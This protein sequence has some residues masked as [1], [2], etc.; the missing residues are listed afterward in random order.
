[1]DN[2]VLCFPCSRLV[3]ALVV[4]LQQHPFQSVIIQAPSKRKAERA[5]PSKSTYPVLLEAVLGAEEAVLNAQ[6]QARRTLQSTGIVSAVHAQALLLWWGLRHGE[7]AGRAE[8][9][10]LCSLAR[11]LW[12]LCSSQI[13]K[14]YRKTPRSIYVLLGITEAVSTSTRSS[15]KRKIVVK[16]KVSRA[17]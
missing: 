1:M 13:G 3:H 12:C 14:L 6:L 2:T 5:A 8:R 17:G 10:V 16:G 11:S 7:V 15:K 4:T 9:L